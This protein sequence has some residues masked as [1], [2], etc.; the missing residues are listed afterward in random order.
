VVSLASDRRSD[1]PAADPRR[2]IC[3]A[4]RAF[5]VTSKRRAPG[6]A[7]GRRRRTLASANGDVL[8]LFDGPPCGE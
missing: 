8:Y 6:P 7:Y 3:G 1:R 5:L 2:V 4:P